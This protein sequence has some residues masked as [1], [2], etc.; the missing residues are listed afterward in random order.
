LA[1]TPV[2]GENAADAVVG[3][4]DR[5]GIDLV[6]IERELRDARVD[7]DLRS[8]IMRALA[9]SVHER[10]GSAGV[11][12]ADLRAWIERRPIE[13][14]RPSA[15]RRGILLCRRRPV[16]VGAVVIALAGC[17]TTVAAVENTRRISIENTA[18]AAELDIERAKREADVAWR[19][20]TLDSL[21]RLLSG[22]QSAKDQGLGAQVL[23]SLWVLEWAHGPTLLQDPE[24]LGAI[25][26]TRIDMLYAVRDQARRHAGPD[27]IEARLT[28]PSLVLWLLRDG[29]TAEARALLA[30]AIPFWQRHTNA[31]DPW[32]DDLLLLESLVVYAELS[33][34]AGERGLE[35]AEGV[36]L[37][38]ATMHLKAAQARFSAAGDRGP[39][40]QLLRDFID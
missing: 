38:N 8:I 34:V 35:T 31:S 24:A 37:E 2:A 33:G 5:G 6:R 3:L 26:S 21:N 10:Y 9:P 13:T 14:L 20:K 32:L 4:G 36:V 18:Q 1:G 23:T 16:A 30:E 27:S 40:A 12:A 29:R 7:R 28:E 15:W 25:W 22:F 39:M 17:A 11:L 19:K